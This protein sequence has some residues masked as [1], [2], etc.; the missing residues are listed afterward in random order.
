MYAG[1]GSTIYAIDKNGNATELKK[2]QQGVPQDIY[3]NKGYLYVVR[4]NPNGKDKKTGINTSS[5]SGQAN[6]SKNIIDVY[7]NGEYV[8]SKSIKTGGEN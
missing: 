3:A 5:S 4:Y 7:K 8:G 2:I 1:A 6:S